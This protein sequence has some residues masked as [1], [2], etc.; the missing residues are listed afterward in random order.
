M[1]FSVPF[2]MKALSGRVTF[3]DGSVVAGANVLVLNNLNERMSYSAITD[4]NGYYNIDF[5]HQ[6]SSGV[7][8]VTIG[9]EPLLQ[10]V[11]IDFDVYVGADIEM[12]L[13]DLMGNNIATII[14]RKFEQGEYNISWDYSPYKCYVENRL[15]LISLRSGKKY[16]TAKFIL[17]QNGN[18]NSFYTEIVTIS[19]FEKEDLVHSSYS[20]TV[21]GNGFN[22]HTINSIDLGQKENQNIVVRRDSWVPFCCQGNYFGIYMGDTYQDL[23]VK[24]INLGGGI[25]GT[26]P[27]QM[28]PSAEQYSKWF[29][30]M[31]DAGFNLIRVYTLHYP[32]FYEEL[33]KY[34]LSNPQKPLYVIHGA[35]LDEEYEGFETNP[36]LFN[37]T[38]TYLPD[39]EEGAEY[40]TKAI[41]DYFDDR[42]KE[43]IDVVHGNA[44]LPDRPG[45]ASGDYRADI[46]PWLVGYIIGREIYALE[47]VKTNANEA[48]KQYTH[49]NGT[50]FSLNEGTPSEVWAAARLDK[51]MAYEKENYHQ[52]HPISFSSW[53]SL[54]PIDHPTE[55]GPEDMVAINLDGID[56]TN[57][58]AGYFA[59]YHVYPYFPD[60]MVCDPGYRSYSDEYGENSYFGYLIDLKSHYKNRPLIIS[61]YGVSSGWGTSRFSTNGMHH[62]GLTEE[63]QGKY[64]IR[65][66][67]N[68]NDAGCGG[69][70]LFSWIDEWFKYVWIFGQTT[71][72]ES[73]PRWHNI[74]SA[75][76]N[77]GLITFIPEDPD[78]SKF[79]FISRTDDIVQGRIAYDTEGFYVKAITKKELG[80]NDTLWLAI[81]T[82]NKGKGE[83]KLPNGKLVY[84]RAEFCVSVTKSK[85]QLFVTKAYDMFGIGQE[86]FPANG[87]YFRSV[88]SDKGDWNEVKWKNHRDEFFCAG[89]IFNAGNLKIRNNVS[90]TRHDGVIIDGHEI[91]VK[92]PWG[93]IN[94]ND[95]SQLQVSHIT[96]YSKNGINYN[97]TTTSDGV[98]VTIFLNGSRLT[99][100]RFMWDKWDESSMPKT[101]EYKKSSFQIVKKGLKQ[102]SQ[103]PQ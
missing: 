30:E 49:L 29:G 17:P 44:N 81:D 69:G 102:F 27:S 16:T 85:A 59:S 38:I 53:P 13:F 74:Y 40:Q 77:Y 6:V 51:A 76:E 57:A 33:R 68:I 24:G 88:A 9:V 20:I 67:N 23:F 45:W 93:L 39:R 79:G 37:S 95:P 14:N 52:Q 25:P 54:D 18:D 10:K 80:D 32:R 78:F 63:E 21:T 100:P 48:N 103:Y 34:N 31:A 26:Y 84:N 60:F 66:M 99:I 1:F 8:A 12:T 91:T 41:V 65:M 42:V 86:G 83:S 4:A 50:V 15:I 94:F 64:I 90:P 73:R 75:E 97:Q 89:T 87:Q 92:L 11:I 3:F 101:F 70:I 46:S 7:K 72:P 35:W 58:P 98:A 56:E 71:N 96:D 22:D 47:V 28:A 43:V 2:V 62:G 36:D 82:Y 5:Q 61:E 19:D 55:S